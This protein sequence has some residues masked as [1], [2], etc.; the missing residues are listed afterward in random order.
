[1]RPAV[2]LK[3]WIGQTQ[4]PYITQTNNCT[5]HNLTSVHKTNTMVGLGA[6]DRG[7]REEGG[8]GCRAEANDIT[9][10]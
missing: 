6:A 1:M 4:K 10:N 3:L 2:D 5:E 9:N 8:R 7:A